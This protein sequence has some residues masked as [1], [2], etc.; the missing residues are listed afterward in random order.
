MF[1]NTWIPLEALCACVSALDIATLKIRS[2]TK[3]YVKQHA[4]QNNQESD[5]RLRKN[6]ISHGKWGKI[7]TK[8]RT[9]WQKLSLVFIHSYSINCLVTKSSTC[10]VVNGLIST[11]TTNLVVKTWV[12]S[13]W[14]HVRNPSEQYPTCQQSLIACHHT[15]TPF[16]WPTWAFVSPPCI[17]GVILG[18]LNSP[19]KLRQFFLRNNGKWRGVTTLNLQDVRK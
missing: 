10:F 4:N 9:I 2:L 12:R 5:G 15:P 16:A 11:W 6:N 14:S 8:V 3:C 1:I 18:L 7:W 17:Q 13:A 19:W